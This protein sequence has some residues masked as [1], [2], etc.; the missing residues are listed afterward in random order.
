MVT[1]VPD[2]LVG[3]LNFATTE[4]T[5]P[6]VN[7]SATSETRRAGD[8]SGW[9]KGEGGGGWGSIGLIGTDS[10]VKGSSHSGLGQPSPTPLSATPPLSRGHGSEWSVQTPFE[11]TRA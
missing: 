2:A 3:L 8:G 6:V 9:G 4:A 10:G 11:Q 7:P 1:V 5:R